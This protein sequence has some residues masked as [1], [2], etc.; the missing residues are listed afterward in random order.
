[1]VNF[2]KGLQEKFSEK[3]SR[4]H[5]GINLALKKQITKIKNNDYAHISTEA[6]HSLSL[7]ESIIEL[8]FISSLVDETQYFM[9]ALLKLYETHDREQP[10]LSAITERIRRRLQQ[11]CLLKE[12]LLSNKKIDGEKNFTGEE[13]Q[14]RAERANEISHNL[15]RDEL[16]PDE[17]VFP[18]A[19]SMVR[20][21][22]IKIGTGK[23]EGA[24][25]PILTAI[26][27]LENINLDKRL[28]ISHTDIFTVAVASNA[29][30]SREDREKLVVSLL[31]LARGLL[32][33]AYKEQKGDDCTLAE[34]D[35][36]PYLKEK[37][38]AIEEYGRSNPGDNGSMYYDRAMALSELGKYEEAISDFSRALNLQP[39]LTSARYQRGL[40]L[41]RSGDY[42]NSVADFDET[43]KADSEDEN[44]YWHRATSF[45]AL[46]EAERAIADFSRVI[47]LNDK[48]ELAH[49]YRG[50]IYHKLGND[51]ERGGRAKG[52]YYEKALAD[53]RWVLVLNPISPVTLTKIGL[54]EY[55]IGDEAGAMTE[56]ESA[57]ELDKGA[58]EAKLALDVAKL[59]V[60]MDIQRPEYLERVRGIVIQDT[61]WTDPEF[62]KEN[63]WGEA[64][65]I[66]LL[67]FIFSK[68]QTFED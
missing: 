46:G 25:W 29:L 53:Y 15:Y 50:A 63:L 24:I 42:I 56:W 66:S 47:E 11:F 49:F 33:R 6:D 8:E 27:I 62:L 16:L 35:I 32:I 21:G 13:N 23:S 59:A 52:D 5:G 2:F 36:Y 51:Y 65:R 61:R 54:V 68:M 57:I 58:I 14:R 44:V 22:E 30:L 48:R 55:E 67:L 41:A 40:L 17:F 10:E 4:T 34:D 18:I 31:S 39:D 1:M 20:I 7:I 64:L 43:L 26:D 37:K 19:Y 3:L 9:E 38:K 60:E 12:L 28:V 45:V